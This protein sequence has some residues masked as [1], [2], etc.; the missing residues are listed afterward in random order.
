MY[1]IINLIYNY[2]D[3]YKFHLLT[4]KNSDVGKIY[5]YTSEAFADLWCWRES[6][7]EARADFYRFYLNKQDTAKG[8]QE[9]S[10]F[11]K[12][13]KANKQII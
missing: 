2:M 4:S 11:E 10:E 5:R 12:I 13:K 3:K 1:K 7:G 9:L 8:M 6:E